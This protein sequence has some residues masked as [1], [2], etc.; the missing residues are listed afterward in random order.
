MPSSF[1][2]FIRQLKEQADIVEI[3]GETVELRRAGKDYKGRCP[4]H[5]EK[6]PSFTVSQDKGTYH[7]YGC[8]ASGSVIDFVMNTER[9]P[10]REAVEVLARRLGMELP[11]EKPG[12]RAARAEEDRRRQAVFDAND[13]ALA[14]FRRALAENRHPAANAYLPRRGITPQLVERFEIGAAPDSW[15]ALADHL[16]KIGFS[17][18]LL[19]EA[20]L[21]ARSESGRVYDRF[22]NRLIFPIRDAH[23]R[24]CGFGGRTL[25]D[26]PK[27]PKYLNSSETAVYKKSQILYALHIARHDIEAVGYS[28]LCEG[29]MDVVIAHAHGF[30]QAVASLGTALTPQQANLLRRH[31]R[32]TFFLYD[33][34]AAGQKNM[35][36]GGVHL[37]A[38]AMDV[39]VIQLPTEHDPDSFLRE[40]GPDAL[41]AKLD[42]APEYFDYA[43]AQTERTVEKD[44][45]AGQ[46]EFV[47]RLA[48][49]LLALA[50][51]EAMYLA[52]VARVSQK[53]NGL[54][55]PA[56]DS[57][58]ARVRRGERAATATAPSAGTAAGRPGQ[59]MLEQ[60]LL[61]VMLESPPAL[62]HVRAHLQPEWLHDRH[63]LPW[64]EYL[65]DNVGEARSLI[66]ELE[67]SGEFPADRGPLYAT[68]SLDLPLGDGLEAA[69]EILDRLHERHLLNLSKR[70]IASLGDLAND[71]EKQRQLLKVLSEENRQRVLRLGANRRAGLYQPGSIRSGL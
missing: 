25:S 22:R 6:T 5:Q 46:A 33:G 12:D 60:G 51:N 27:T 16:R 58:L 41:R 29:Y 71:E 34:D 39:R 43:M 35:M 32:K 1:K 40:Q 62:D 67:V 30:P 38:E 36:S 42:G 3:V 53:L 45:L 66:D 61:K 52:A 8:G 28:I 70:L 68:L 13:A 49:M 21:C 10:F 37:L 20:G 50:K 14:F 15:T 57:I 48:P 23:G 56:V 24:L 2:D 18:E 69:C 55:R 26:D 4:F 64:I 7:C 17:D 59:D 54:P 11:A 65:H 47:E 63:L 31:A 44:T 19:L 9:L